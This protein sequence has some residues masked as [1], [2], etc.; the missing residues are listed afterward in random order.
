MRPPLHS[1]HGRSYLH[2]MT[3]DEDFPLYIFPKDA[4]VQAPDITGTSTTGFVTSFV[5]V[6]LTLWP[7]PL[8][9][10]QV[11][12]PQVYCSH[13]PKYDHTSISPASKYVPLSYRLV[14]ASPIVA[15]QTQAAVAARCNLVGFILH[16]TV[17]TI[18]CTGLA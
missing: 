11:D 5:V 9:S 17:A 15:W 18:P 8:V 16:S 1:C 4:T 7:N 13:S 6:V 2:R 12:F 14:V 10:L 3:G